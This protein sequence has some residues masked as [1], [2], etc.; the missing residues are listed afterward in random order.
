MSEWGIFNDEGCIESQF[1]S[2][3]EAEAAMAVLD[4]IGEEQFLSV[5]RICPDHEEQPQDTCEEC[6]AEE[7]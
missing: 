7:E 1:Y 3:D 6:F 2:V 5:H 4:A